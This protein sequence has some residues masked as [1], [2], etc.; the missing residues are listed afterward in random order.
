M[1]NDFYELKLEVTLEEGNLLV[2][3]VKKARL[4]EATENSKLDRILNLLEIMDQR[5]RSLGK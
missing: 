4:G 5:N 2:E 3:L 1:G